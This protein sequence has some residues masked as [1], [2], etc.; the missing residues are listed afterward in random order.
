MPKYLLGIDNGCTLS[1][2]ALYD[3][4][5]RCISVS[6]YKTKLII[7]QYGFIERDMVELWNANVNVIKNIISE[8]C[9]DPKEI[10][11]ISI[12]GH[13]NGVYLVGENGEPVYN[14]IISTDSRAKDYI[15]KWYQDGT[16][17]KVFPKTIQSIWAGQPVAILAWF[18]EHNPNILK[19]IKWIFMCKDYIRY[20]LTGEAFAEITDISGTNLMNISDLKYDEELLQDF[21]LEDIICKLPPIRYSS[22]I[23]GYVTKKAADLTGLEEGIPIAGGLFDID[24]CAI[25]TGVINTD[26]FCIVAGT[27]SINEFVTRKP[28]MSKDLFSNTI[29]CIPGYWLV[30]EGSPTSASNL[31]WFVTQFFGEENRLAKKKGVSIYT[32]CDKMVLNIKPE[33]NDLIFMPFLFGS[34]V[35]V[36]ARACFI[37]LN[38]LHTKANILRSVYEG[39][40]FSHLYHIEKLLSFRDKPRSISISGRASRSKAW[41][42]IF[43][44]II[45]IP[46]EVT[47]GTELGTLGAAICSGIATGKFTSYSNAVQSMVRIS[48]ICEP[49]IECMK[50]YKKK[51]QLYKKAIELLDP[52]WKEW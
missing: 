32:I 1:K 48:Y 19:K 35:N 41:V 44:D 13:G 14:G 36:N 26:K 27:W 22:D 42:Q 47:C 30:L 25:A 37:G 24:A 51:Y 15:K 38:G 23:C 6:S 9:I 18:K 7:P 3:L 46:I 39:I 10:V 33:D 34:N 50:I 43:A 20:C 21:G 49:D 8:S 31:E 2:A 11:G 4:K 16:F 40:V 5:G 29:F 12:T 45:Q 52:L 17:E 28:I